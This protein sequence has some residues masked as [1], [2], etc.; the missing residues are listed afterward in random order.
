M[1]QCLNGAI[2]SR[3]CSIKAPANWRNSVYVLME[4]CHQRSKWL[5]PNSSPPNKLTMLRN[6]LWKYITKPLSPHLRI[7]NLWPHRCIFPSQFTSH[8]AFNNV[9]RLKIYIE[10]SRKFF[11]KNSRNLTDWPCF[12]SSASCNNLFLSPRDFSAH[13]SKL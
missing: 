8:F 4:I 6:N 7:G 9:N 2:P 3:K 5:G 13:C 1:C 10:M 11:L 12:F